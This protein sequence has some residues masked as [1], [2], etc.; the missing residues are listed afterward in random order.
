MLADVVCQEEDETIPSSTP[1][2]RIRCNPC[3]SRRLADFLFMLISILRNTALKGSLCDDTLSATQ[4]EP[5]PT[6]LW[7]TRLNRRLPV[8]QI[9]DCHKLGQGISR[10]KGVPLGRVPGSSS[11]SPAD[12][13]F[14]LIS[15][16]QNTTPNRR[17]I[18]SA[19]RFHS[20]R[21]SLIYFF[22]S[23]HILKL[24]SM[25]F[26]VRLYAFDQLFFKYYYLQTGCSTKLT[27]DSNDEIF[28]I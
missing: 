22:K 14:K 8:T 21:I 13:L 23:P 9:I 1:P 26:E 11:R 15:N 24:Y 10:A 5:I 2:L 4:R 19:N 25:N 17:N 20:L 3:S 18:N 7:F 16:Q 6:Q 27:S 28:V 12:F